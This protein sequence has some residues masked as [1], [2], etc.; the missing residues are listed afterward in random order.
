M[1]GF[2]F[3]AQVMVLGLALAGYFKADLRKY[4]LVRIPL[5]FVLSNTAILVASIRL[6][7]GESVI[8]WDPSKKG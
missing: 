8:V 5:F 2:V 1:W 6:L 4:A 3:W 7:K